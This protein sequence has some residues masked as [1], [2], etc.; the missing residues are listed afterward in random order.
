MRR[1]SLVIGA[2]A[3]GVVV[4]ASAALALWSYAERPQLN[5]APRQWYRTSAP[6]VL[7]PVEHSGSLS[8]LRARVDGR[9]AARKLRRTGDGLVLELDG[10]ADGTHRVLVQASPA[11]VFGDSVDEAF[12]IHVDTHR[13]SLALNAAPSGW[14]SASELSGRVEAGS[15]LALSFSGTRVVLHP[16]T[17]TFELD[18]KLPDGRTTVKLIASDRAGNSSVL[19][20][21]VAVDRTAPRVHVDRVPGVLG[22][23][24]PTLRGSIDDASPVS[25]EALLDG[26]SVALR[27]PDGTA[28]LG[29]HVKSGR[30]SLPLEHLAQGVHNLWVMATD[31]AG[32]TTTAI[33]GPFTVD[34][35]EKLHASTVLSLG[36]RGADVVQLER[37]LKAFGTYHGPFTRFYNQRTED[38]VSAFQRGHKLPVTGI[39]TPEV[40]QLSAERIVV[41]LSQFRV[42]LIRDG[43]RVFSAPIA[44]GQPAYPTPTGSYEVIVKIKNPTWVPPNSPWAAGLEAIP[45]GASNPLGSRWIGTSAPN[46]GF[47]ATPMDSTVGHAASHGCMRMHR[48]DVERLYDLVRVGTP[49]DIEV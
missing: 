19:T 8:D 46:I 34:S 7:V 32:N 25:V 35:T 21:T 11:R 29:A 14:Q 17:G 4:A 1:R 18:P 12:T 6:Q 9:N 3:G 30:F 13:P 31:S 10:L 42:F 39:A 2:I 45:P 16:R 48:A 22:T 40:L 5:G 47:H 15:T 38:A 49:V 28:L 24:H 44:I 27:R 43:K 20:R 26:A 36:A 23:A 33:A 41:H 37:R